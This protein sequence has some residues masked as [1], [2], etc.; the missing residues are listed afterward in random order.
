[1]RLIDWMETTGTTIE[2]LAEKS[3]VSARTI[4]NIRR[5][6]SASFA[7]AALIE[8]ATGGTVTIHELTG[9]SEPDGKHAA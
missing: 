4:T 9:R 3:G 1:M 2:Q 7:V 5:D 8:N 6:N